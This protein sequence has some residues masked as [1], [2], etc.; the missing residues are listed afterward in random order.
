MNNILDTS[1]QLRAI[2]D[3]NDPF[4]TTGHQ[5]LK[6]RRPRKK[7]PSWVHNNKKIREFLL[8]SFPK[9][10]TDPRQRARAGRWVRIIHLYYN[11]NWSRGQIAEELG[12]GYGVVSSSIRR[13]GLAARGLRTDGSGR[14]LGA[15]KGRPKKSCSH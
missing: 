6:I 14:P 2:L 3:S 4:M 15:K 10:K 5:I 7:T 1:K 8:Q 9:M 11:Q 12:V 13:I